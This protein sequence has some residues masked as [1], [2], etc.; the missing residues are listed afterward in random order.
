MGIRIRKPLGP[1][2]LSG[3]NVST[4][5][6]YPSSWRSNSTGLPVPTWHAFHSQRFPRAQVAD[7][8]SWAFIPQRGLE[9]PSTAWTSPRFSLCS[10]LPAPRSQ[11]EPG[12]E[13]Q[14]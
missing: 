11:P 7:C 5:P 13:P 10:L 3:W 4:V 12:T 1:A 2:P 14:T 6:L 9:R 8:A